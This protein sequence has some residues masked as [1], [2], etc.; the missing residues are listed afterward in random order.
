[1]SGRVACATL[2]TMSSIAAICL[3][4]SNKHCGRQR[5]IQY[6]KADLRSGEGP[7]V[8]CT[9][10]LISLSA[11]FA[12][13]SVNRALSRG[14]AMGRS[15]RLFVCAHSKTGS[16]PDFVCRMYTHSLSVHLPNSQ[17]DGKT[18]LDSCHCAKAQRQGWTYSSW[19]AWRQEPTLDTNGGPITNHRAQ[20][21]DTENKP[22][23]RIIWRRDCIASP[24]ANAYCGGGST[25]GPAMTFGYIAGLNAA[26]DLGKTN[27]ESSLVWAEL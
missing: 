6:S 5:S 16:M 15:K 8:L 20:V 1:M 3:C 19:K 24:R 9:A 12:Y 26:Q 23:F 25:I 17:R 21:L 14:I 22:I 4:P 27:N 18:A 10:R 7:S 2:F 13:A 11:C